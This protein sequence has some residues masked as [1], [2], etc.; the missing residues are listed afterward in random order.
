MLQQSKK[1]I[2]LLSFAVSG[3]MMLFAFSIYFHFDN[4]I[5]QD[6]GRHLTLGKIICQTKKI[7]STNLFSYTYTNYP[8][9]NHHWASEVIFYLL[10]QLGSIT[11]LI[12]LELMIILIIVGGL[13]F[14]SYKHTDLISSLISC[15]IMLEI[16]RERTDIRP[17]IFGYFLFFLVLVILYQEKEKPSKLIL[18]L[19]LIGTVWVNL[20]ISFIFLLIT[21]LIFLADRLFFKKNKAKYLIIGLLVVISLFINPYGIAGA[22]YPLRI[23]Q[24]YGYSIAENQS[25]FFLEKLMSSSTI[26]YFKVAVCLLMLVTPFLFRKHFFELGIAYAT[27][28]FSIL[29]I[30]H[31]PFFALA[32]FLPLS[33][34]LFYLKNKLLS[35]IKITPDKA[36]LLMLILSIFVI[37]LIVIETYSLISN[38]YYKEIKL[39][40]ER[41]GIGQVAGL[42]NTVDFFL[43]NNFTGPI[44]NN[45]DIGSYLI[46]RFYPQFLVFIDG[47]PEAYPKN[48]FRQIYIPMQEDATIWKEMVKKYDLRT[49]IF[50]HTDQTPWAKK[51]IKRI[52]FDSDWGL[53]YLDDYGLILIRRDIA[54]EDIVFYDSREKLADLGRNLII[55]ADQPETLRRLINIFSLLGYSDLVKLSKMRARWLS[56][57]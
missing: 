37:R 12:F 52:I 39:S 5:T 2:N 41:F 38:K 8:F 46:Y 29:A 55:K 28:G 53:V 15:F 21:Y 16:V 57:K 54:S 51:F 35:W 22:S 1:I 9:I 40:S 36:I 6:L 47:R 31:F 44:F 10:Y 3:I 24:N 49:I 27:A 48:F 50:S 43:M 23:F 19:P 4:A 11:G 26:L 30:R 20:H 13:L 33:Q 42:K 45:F 56:G 14:A 32:C 34:G 18:L 7:P 25:I 17:E